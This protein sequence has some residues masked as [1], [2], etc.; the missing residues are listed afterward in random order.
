ML[1]A[2]PY[3]TAGQSGPLGQAWASCLNSAA[4][5]TTVTTAVA[6]AVA[7]AAAVAAAA[8]TQNRM[9]N[10]SFNIAHLPMVVGSSI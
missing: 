6:T 8:E 2:L 5:A 3:C 9:Y 1:P 4:V 7:T 10:C